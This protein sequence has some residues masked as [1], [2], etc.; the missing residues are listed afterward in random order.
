MSPVGGVGINLAIQDAVAA[1]NQLTAPLRENRVTLS[2]LAKVQRRRMFP[3]RM[4]QW[5]QLQI[6]NRI[7]GRVLANPRP[8][9]PVALLRLLRW[10]PW[11]RRLP[12]RIIGLGFRP[13]HIRTP[14]AFANR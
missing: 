5:L 9:R 2:D 4:T 11:L 10:F 7:L 3:T 8:I 13:E 12:P 1:A 6:Q 14:D